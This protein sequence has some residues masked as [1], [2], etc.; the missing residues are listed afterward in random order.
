MDK[1]SRM[2]TFIVVPEG[3]A[4]D[5]RGAY[6]ASDHYLAA[7]DLVME[8][9]SPSDT[10]YLAPANRFGAHQAEDLFARDYLLSR[11][12]P[13]QVEVI[14]PEI[15]RRGYLDTLD[16][17]HVLKMDLM[18]K[19]RWPLGS[20]TLVCN[21]P[22]RLRSRLMFRLCGYEVSEVRTSRAGERS[23]TRMVG[24]L[25]FYDIPVLQYFYEL[26]ATAYGCFRFPFLKDQM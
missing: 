2:R 16:N 26:L 4:L 7:L 14:S 21:R 1:R 23:G 20:V 5:S 24:R 17:A 18:R 22:H 12:C 19:G 11:H 6:H 25:W 9:S 3:L 10:I 13:A 8:F 15:P